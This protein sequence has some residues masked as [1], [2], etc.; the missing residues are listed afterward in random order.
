MMNACKPVGVNKKFK[1]SMLG[2][3]EDS[4]LEEFREMG[5]NGEAQSLQLELINMNKD[6]NELK[7]KI[8]DEIDELKGELG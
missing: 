1:N 8:K 5:R 3:R 4:K 7:N 2:K 6:H